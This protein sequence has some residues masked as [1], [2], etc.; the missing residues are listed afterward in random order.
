[1][2]DR[3]S[4]LQAVR[5]RPDEDGP[6]LALADWYAGTGEPDRAEFIRIQVERSRLPEEDDRHSVLHAQELRL[7]AAHTADW[8]AGPPLLRFARFRRGFAEY[9]SGPAAEVLE[10]LPEAARQTPVREIRLT[11]LGAG[12]GLGEALAQRPEL[13]HIDAVAVDDMAGDMA[14]AEQ[15]VRLFSGP[16]LRRVRRLTLFCG[17]CNADV[18]RQLL[19]L[20]ALGEVEELYFNGGLQPIHRRASP[21]HSAGFDHDI[22]KPAACR[23]RS[24]A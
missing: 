17:E 12:D 6:R 14:P 10:Q 24:N 22:R 13:A 20:P 9:F 2:S 19:S 5:E 4:L 18:L 1:M 7:L 16:H 21:N 8:L 3:E 23:S 11:N 15:L